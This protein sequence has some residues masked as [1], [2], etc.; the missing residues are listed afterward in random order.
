MVIDSSALLALFYAEPG[1]ETIKE[2]IAAAPRLLISAVTMVEASVAVLRG[3]GAESMA[4]FELI[5]E[6]LHAQVI[7]FDLEQAVLARG[8]YVR[9]GTGR[10]AARLNL[11]DCMVYGLAKLTGEPLLFKGQDF[12]VTDLAAAR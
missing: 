7:P 5:V 9:Y 11:G 8:A 2:K 4:D 1:V 10:H 6:A 3:L 12:S